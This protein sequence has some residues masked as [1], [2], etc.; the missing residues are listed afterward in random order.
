MGDDASITAA[1]L[2]E[3]YK[4]GHADAY[5]KA[6]GQHKSR[7]IKAPDV[8]ALSYAAGKPLTP[9][10]FEAAT[11]AVLHRISIGD[12]LLA[13][14]ECPADVDA[15]VRAPHRNPRPA[16][17]PSMDTLRNARSRLRQRATFF[18]KP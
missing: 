15:F 1:A 3:A 10:Q 8:V 4:R 6:K 14:K 11:I 9:V 18:T 16:G 7:R 13:G 17:W 2:R 5:R 12:A